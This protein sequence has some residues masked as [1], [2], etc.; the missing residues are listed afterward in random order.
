MKLRR[1]HAASFAAIREVDIE[2]GPG[3]NVLYGPN[4]LGKSTLVAAIRLA[5]LL[6]HASTH[7][8]PYIGWSHAEDPRVE[9][10]FETEAQRIWRVKKVFGKSGLSQLQES[11]NGQDFDDVERGR[12]VDGKIREILRWGISEPG[13][14]G[15]GKGLPASFLATALLSTQS[16]VSAVLHADLQGDPAASGKEQIAAALQAVAQDPLFV[17]LL[18]SAQAKRDEAYTDKGAKKTAKGSIF[19]AAA[20]RV[21]EARNDRDRLERIVADS[22]GAESQ[23]RQLSDRQSLK[24]DELARLTERVAQLEKT[25]A[26]AA[27]REA[28]AL[29]VRLSR[30]D[31]LRIEKLGQDADAA[32]LKLAALAQQMNGAEDKLKAAQE[33]QREADA[34]LSVAEE[35]ARAE[36]ADAGLNDTVV[37]QQYELR[38]SAVERTEDEVRQRIDSISAAQTLVEAAAAAERDLEE[39]NAKAATARDALARAAAKEKTAADDLQRCDLLERALEVHAAEKQAAT[40]QAEV[41]GQ[42]A[43]Q[44]RLETALRERA[45][46]GARRV[47]MHVPAVGALGP[48]RRLANELASARGA[49]ELGLV[50]TVTPFSS[51]DLRVRKDRSKAEPIQAEKPLKIEAKTE[52]EVSIAE[53]GTMRIRAGRREAQEMAQAL[54]DRWSRE[55]EPILAAAG[56]PDLERL[57]GKVTESRDL[58]TAMKTADA[59]LDTL[60]IRID[61]LSGAAEE[62]REASRR[63]KASRKALGDVPLESLAGEFA[64]LGADPIA[65]LRKRRQQLTKELEAARGAAN[66]ASNACTLADERA[67]N[68]QSL[69]EAAGQARLAASKSFP[70]GLAPALAAARKG[71][72][73]AIAEKETIAVEIEKLEGTVAA[74]K[75]LL[76][77]ALSGARQSSETARAAVETA[78]QVLNAAIKDHASQEGELIQLRK[79]RDAAD[80]EAAIAKLG[81]ATERHDALPVPERVVTAEELI[82]AEETAG[83]VGA[84]LELINSETLRAQGALE[85]VG[86]AVAREQL[87]EATEAFDL[88]ERY[89]REIE[90]EYESWKLLLEQMKE[91]DAAQASNLGQTLAPFIAAQFQQLTRQRYESVQLSPQLGT[92]GVLVSGAL[93]SPELIS[94]GTR[95]QLSTLYRLSLAEYL[96]TVIVLDDQLVQS[97]GSRMDWFRMLL[98]EKARSFQIIVVTCRP[99]DYLKASEWVPDGKMVHADSEGGFIRAIDLER[100]VRRK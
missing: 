3:L 38:K 27:D 4:D 48:M 72:A 46:L 59:A 23:L 30:G 99:A 87:R 33:Q 47:A 95:E 1:L 5:L 65:G 78:Q 90:A 39:Q 8:E 55:V 83:A 54:E 42:A 24:Q 11:K 98:N 69:C 76:E 12:K 71:R 26:Q 21:N 13:G 10:T 28:A 14:A 41:N 51:L 79:I 67:R 64:K 88:A 97:D 91:A 96:Q 44:A 74:K 40:A 56:V 57:E 68:A 60:R 75:K 18:R 7:S 92:E 84:Q 85:H 20:E 70:E 2:F 45:A 77:K 15:G 37:R 22:D 82:A 81:E 94:V 61:A 16:D 100:A 19:K 52:I 31:V 73:D 32:A 86:G 58:E 49:L 89:E 17:A 35:A 53:V 6:P 34:E 80:L 36:E 62:L 9:L 66:L 29:E 50:V 63:A 43:L 25:A 93:R